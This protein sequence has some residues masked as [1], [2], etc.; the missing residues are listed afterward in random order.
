[1]T[2]TVALII[3]VMTAHSATS[4]ESA[5]ENCNDIQQIVSFEKHVLCLRYSL[6][7][8]RR[9]NFSINLRSSIDISIVGSDVHKNSHSINCRQFDCRP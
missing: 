8:Y 3:R 7:L 5:I 1:M 6:E 2:T 9:Y 4:A